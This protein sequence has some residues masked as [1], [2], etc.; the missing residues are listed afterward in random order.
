MPTIRIDDLNIN[1][2]IEGQ[3]ESIV[4]IHGLGSSS[5]DWY[6]QTEFFSR[7]FQVIAYDVR[8][9]GLSDKPQGPYSVPMFADD[10]ANLLK[11]W[12]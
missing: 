11:N 5:R 4:F 6:L 12:G 1:Y 9:H 2:E 3:G 10:L 8:G 7:Y